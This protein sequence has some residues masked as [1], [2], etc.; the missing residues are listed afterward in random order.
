MF[1]G[2]HYNQL[3]T[4]CSGNSFVAILRSARPVFDWN[5][6]NV[7]DDEAANEDSDDD[8]ISTII[9]DDSKQHLA[10]T[11]NS[12]PYC[13]V[14]NN[15]V[16]QL[17]NIESDCIHIRAV[18]HDGA[19]VEL[20]KVIN[21]SKGK[22]SLNA[23]E[24]V[25]K[26]DLFLV[27]Y[28][29]DFSRCAIADNDEGA[30][31]VHL[32]DH[33]LRISSINITDLCHIP[34]KCTSIGRMVMPIK[35][36]LPKNLSEEEKS[37]VNI[38]LKKFLNRRFKVVSKKQVVPYSVID[39]IGLSDEIS[40]G[41]AC[42]NS[43]SKRFRFEDITCK[44]IVKT[45]NVDLIVIENMHLSSDICCFVLLSDL[46]TFA[47]RTTELTEF[48]K[49]L[50]N[51][52]A[53]KPDR[54][55]MCLVLYPDEEGTE[56]WY[57]AQFHQYLANDRAQVGLIDFGILVIVKSCH[58]RMFQQQ[59][60]YERLSFTA[61]IRSVDGISRDLLNEQLFTNIS[62]IHVEWLQFLNTQCF[63]I[64]LSEQYYFM[65]NDLVQ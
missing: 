7:S 57:R 52:T 42:Q 1:D 11:L 16:V 21:G 53:Y 12:L 15:D 30:L 37:T 32:I 36:Q 65:E 31:T 28:C 10:P 19:F 20:M 2:Q 33:G 62:Q 14:N 25:Q 24:I 61:K 39:L 55:E 46:Q 56:V 64:G 50:K 4:I 18:K 51:V 8:S 40:L 38:V 41:I 54:L 45:D 6:V 26:D 22:S 23:N 44:K 5:E 29:D 27:S 17:T 49:T 63:E 59:F 48:G 43:I 47:V 9:N 60:G 35:L 3:I 13:D 58:I 34:P